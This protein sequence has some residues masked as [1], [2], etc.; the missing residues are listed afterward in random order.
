MKLLE[1]TGL[2]YLFFFLMANSFSLA[3]PIALPCDY[4]RIDIVISYCFGWWRCCVNSHLF[5]R[6]QRHSELP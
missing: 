4:V 1:N 2:I 5:S 3:S 6:G